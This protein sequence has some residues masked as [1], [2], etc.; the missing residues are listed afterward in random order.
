MPTAVQEPVG[1]PLVI[2]T[3]NG[4]PD[5]GWCNQLSTPQPAPDLEALAE[6]I[7]AGVDYQA[8]CGR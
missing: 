4:D 6:Q 5:R 1:R 2:E 8:R 7:R 3:Q